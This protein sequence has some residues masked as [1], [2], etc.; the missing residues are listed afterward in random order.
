MADIVPTSAPARG[1]ADIPG[2]KQIGLLAGVA[3]AVAAAIWLVLW[4]QGQSYTVLY[5]QLSERESGQVMDALT[6]AGIEFKL[7]PSGAVS[8][9]E[10]KVQEARIRLAS[11]GL[12]QSDSMGI[13][14]IQKESALGNSTMM[15]GARYQSMLE[16][17]LARTIIKVQGVQSARVHLALPKPS[18]FLRDAHKATASVMLQL[19]PGRRLEPGQVAAIVHLVASSVP[20]LGP[21][22]VTLVD[23]AGSLLNSPDEN[24]EA[25]ASARQFE[26]TRKLEQSYQRRIVELLEPMIGPGRVRA[27]VTADLDYTVTESTHEN[28]DPQKTAVRSEQTSNESRKGGEGSEGI[29]GALSNQPPGTSGAP[30]IP[31]AATP[32]NPA[33]PGAQSAA[34]TGPSSSAQR[35]TRNFEVDRTLSYVKQ[36]VGTLKRLNVG[37]V[38]DDW[39]KV[40]ADGKVTTEPMSDTDIKRFTQLI[41]ESIGL[42][43]DRGDQLN[44]LNQAFKSSVAIGPVEG[45]PLWQQPWLTQ[46][47]KQII[48][49]ALVLVVAFLVLRPLMKSLTKSSG[50]LS[51]S[52]AEDVE[53]DRL[54]LSG[55]GKAIKL[56]PSFEQ[57][58]AAART[59][60]GQDP[61]RAAQVVKDWVSADG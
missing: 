22:D 54:S 23:Q 59:L 14:M 44:V 51:A 47:A 49:A 2:L 37:V 21:S 52:A 3:A 4:S 13:E 8:V 29:P 60:V 26:Y 24:A 55:Q 43:D 32:G 6:A 57:Q 31:G 7:N 56:S 16:T 12:P 53:G 19:Y 11:Q 42:K 48:G 30:V 46:L 25:A 28:Y 15:E 40:D 1:L 17:E 50:R 34:A 41:K 33:A 5:G 39:Q 36:P 45:L 20:E 10:S 18:V 58:I 61:R 35:S 9:P 27:T 38:L